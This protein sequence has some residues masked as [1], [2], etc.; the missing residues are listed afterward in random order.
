[1][2]C[3]V[4]TFRATP[5]LDPRLLEV[6]ENLKSSSPKIHRLMKAQEIYVIFKRPLKF[7]M[8]IGAISRWSRARGCCLHIL[9]SNHRV[10]A[11]CFPP[12]DPSHITH[13]AGS[14]FMS[15][16]GK[17]WNKRSSGVSLPPHTHTQ[18]VSLIQRRTEGFEL[19]SDA[20]GFM[21]VGCWWRWASNHAHNSPIPNPKLLLYSEL[22]TVDIFFSTFISDRIN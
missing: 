16:T 22:V 21:A 7:K 19:Q 15:F 9:W 6:E 11:G 8:H 12:L 13:S 3:C 14:Q 5:N 20:K 10:S 17:L 4:G 2:C 1:M 18:K